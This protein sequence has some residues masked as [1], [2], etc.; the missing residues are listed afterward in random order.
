M[1][2]ILLVIAFAALYL[3]GCINDTVD[4]LSKL[5]VQVPIFFY[6]DYLNREAPDISTDFTNLY[7]YPEYIDNKDKIDK[8]EIYQ[9]NY[10]VD[11]LIM[12]NGIPYHPTKF[13][14]KFDYIKFSLVFA[15]PKSS[16]YERSL[17]PN[18][19]T[20]DTEKGEFLLGEYKNVDIADY[21]KQSKNIIAVSDSVGKVV[22]EI[23][24]DKP[25]FFIKTEYSKVTG[26]TEEKD[27]FPLIKA[28]YDLVVR[29]G[30]KF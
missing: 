18:N 27:V 29:L 25:Y 12:Q 14:L 15:K 20:M 3:T 28:K 4:S 6:S 9:F 17:N 11:S 10:R 5:T 1:K 13:S 26:S 16:A 8:S 19:F 30:I 22:S 21:Y 24:K 2:K 23:L 7:E